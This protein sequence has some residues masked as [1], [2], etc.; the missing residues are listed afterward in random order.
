MIYTQLNIGWNADPN[1]PMTTISVSG[2]TV[3]L[4]FYLNYF[5]YD[6]FKEGDK[7]RLTFYNCHK[8]YFGRPNDE[9]YFYGQHRYKH[10]DLPFGKFYL[11]KTDWVNDFQTDSKVLNSDIDFKDLKHY[12]FFFK[13]DTFECI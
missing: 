7:G 11:L 9:G 8:Y 6:Q 13:E 12:I 10:T 2:D 3:T 4:D 1:A 5:I